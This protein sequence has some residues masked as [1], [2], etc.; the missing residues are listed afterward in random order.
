[1]IRLFLLGSTMGAL[2][3]QRGLFPLHGS[4]VETPRGAMVF[5]GKQGA[6]K[7]TLAAEFHRRGYR[8]LSDDVCAVQ[9]TERGLLILP[10][11]AQVRLCADAYERLGSPAD[12]RFDVDK[13]IMPMGERY[14]PDPVPLGAVHVL[15][16]TDIDLPRYE[17]MRGLGRVQC[18]LE[19][20]YRPYY[21]KGQGTQAFLARMAG[22]IAQKIA[23]NVVSRRRE[24][25]AT[26]DLARFLELAW[27]ENHAINSETGNQI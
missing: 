20:L 13:F 25:T 2:L 26:E 8:L 3:Y 11:V 6:G 9:K 1:M 17:P 15:T 4:A 10:A 19:N 24:T 27:A 16:D 7:S 14:C 23:V 21:L 5:V 12:A 22:E 18:L